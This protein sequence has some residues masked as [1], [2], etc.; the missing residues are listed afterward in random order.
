MKSIKLKPYTLNQFTAK[1]GRIYP[2]ATW[3]PGFESSMLLKTNH[4]FLKKFLSTR[5]TVLLMQNEFTVI[6]TDA[7]LII[8]LYKHHVTIECIATISSQRRQGK[9]SKLM[10]RL[11]KI[12]DE[13]GT[14]LKI[15]VKPVTGRSTDYA[16]NTVA[17]RAAEQKGKIPTEKLPKWFEKFGFTKTKQD[18]R[19][20]GYAM[21]RTPIQKRNK[22][23]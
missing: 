15:I 23:K 2:R 1:D 6:G 10:K 7:S 22:N 3:Q 12:A 9:G 20:K 19:K 21:Q 8:R 14:T 18:K 5:L 4:P 11:T 16:I 17:V 13:T